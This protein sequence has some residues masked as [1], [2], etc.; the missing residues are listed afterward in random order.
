MAAI[1]DLTKVQKL[2]E[3]NQSQ[4]LVIVDTNIL[5]NENTPDISKWK[6]SVNNP[7]FLLSDV[8]MAEI[9]MNHAKKVTADE[10]RFARDAII[11][12]INQGNIQDGI[13]IPDV[14]WFISVKA[15]PKSVIQQALDQ[16][17][18]IAGSL[19]QNDTLLLLLTKECEELINNTKAVFIT[20]DSYLFM[21]GKSHVSAILLCENFP[22]TEF[23]NWCNEI[24]KKGV[25]VDWEKELTTIQDNIQANSVN[26]VVVEATLTDYKSGPRWLGAESLIIA[27]GN[28]IVYDGNQI[29]SFLWTIPFYPRNIINIPK[30]SDENTTDLPSIHI[31]FLDKDDFGRN[32]FD[33]VADRLVDCVNLS[34]ED[35]KPT[36]QNPDSVMQ[37]LIYF[38][39]IDKNGISNNTIEEL[40]NE[41]DESEGLANYWAAWILNKDNSEL[42]GD[43]RF[44]CL[45]LL[46]DAVKNCWKI[47]YTY[48]FSFIPN[49]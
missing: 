38:E 13:H 46:V 21:S 18:I 28:G 32:L 42:Y 45:T 1:F 9:V 11:K 4:A 39:Y 33:G 30:S 5:M 2:I 25:D 36:L 14:G 44:N 48:K 19:G 6:S 7:V 20:S 37:M 27:E 41:V 8:V 24:K 29:R 49:K 10:P 23:E 3:D 35:G 16:V 47:G 12:L 40:R 43:E 17:P 15:P 31:D 34:F 22:C 26:S